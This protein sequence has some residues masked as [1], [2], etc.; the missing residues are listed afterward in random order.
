MF[1]GQQT[2]RKGVRRKKVN[3]QYSGDDDSDMSSVSSEGEDTLRN[4]RN[5]APL[6]LAFGRSSMLEKI[7]IDIP[8][9]LEDVAEEILAYVKESRYTVATEIWAKSK[10]EVNDI[11]QQVC[12]IIDFKCF[13][14]ILF[15]VQSYASCRL[16]FYRSLVIVIRYY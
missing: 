3:K 13:M 7:T 12:M 10:Q 5:S 14:F 2:K 1:R 8:P 16:K 6:S 15:S 9:Q 11:M 4:S